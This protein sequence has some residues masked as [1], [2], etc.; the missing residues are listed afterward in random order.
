[1]S[2]YYDVRSHSS[3]R[4]GYAS[5]ARSLDCR[6]SANSWTSIPTLELSNHCIS[7]DSELHRPL[8]PRRSAARSHTESRPSGSRPHRKVTPPRSF[9]NLRSPQG[10]AKSPPRRERSN[11]ARLSRQDGS[12][13]RLL[14]DVARLSEKWTGSSTRVPGAVACFP[15]TTLGT[16][17]V[18][19]HP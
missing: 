17:R 7:Q 9:H 6:F 10:H 14:Q 1:M 12:F 16:T 3:H 13:D 5:A 8:D 4:D 15:P 2:N 19:K 11:P 18:I